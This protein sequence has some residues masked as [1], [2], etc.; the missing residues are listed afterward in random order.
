MDATAADV[1]E[2]VALDGHAEVIAAD[3]H[4]IAPQIAEVGIDYAHSLRA[5]EKHRSRTVEC[6]VGAQDALALVHHCA[7]RMSEGQAFQPNVM[8]R[9]S[10]RSGNHNEIVERGAFEAGA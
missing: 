2:Q 7:R 3:E 1:L 10:T 6:P 5:L 8:D 4:C 9:R